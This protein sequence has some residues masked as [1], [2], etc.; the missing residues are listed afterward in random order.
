MTEEELMH[1]RMNH[2]VSYT[3]MQVLSKSGAQ[4]FNPHLKGTKRQCNV[5]IHANIIRNPAPPASTGQT[6]AVRD[7]SFDLFDMGKIATIAGNRP[8]NCSLLIDNG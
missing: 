4:G 6:A 3:K 5:C 2:C 1:L 8:G 7:M